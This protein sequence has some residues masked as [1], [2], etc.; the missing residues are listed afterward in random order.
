[1][2][3]ART[4]NKKLWSQ[5][6]INIISLYLGI[7][8][9]L[10]IKKSHLQLAKEG[11]ITPHKTMSKGKL[12]ARGKIYLND[13]SDTGSKYQL[14]KVENLNLIGAHKQHKKGKGFVAFILKGDCIYLV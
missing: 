6:T 2:D 7:M 1:M 10:P 13:N 9:F 5:L 8:V 4:Y 11:R 14:Y 3:S 12:Y